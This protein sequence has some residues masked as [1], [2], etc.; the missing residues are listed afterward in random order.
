M[1]RLFLFIFIPGFLM[2][3]GPVSGQTR[4]WETSRSVGF[5]YPGFSARYL[6]RYW[7]LEG[8]YMQQEGVK[9]FGPRVYHRINPGSQ[10][11]CYVGG[12]YAR[13]L[14][15]SA[16]QSFTGRALTAFAGLE[17]FAVRRLS[18][19]LDMGPSNVDLKSRYDDVS[20]GETSLV[21]NLGLHFYL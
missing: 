6:Y 8:L 2:G 12:E 15:K 13:I 18:V 21:V 9:A 20:A 11:V 4:D 7:A 17:L 10:T 1:R 5:H 16:G 19:S 14:G 3:V